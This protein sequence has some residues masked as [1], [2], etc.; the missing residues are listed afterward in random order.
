M[1]GLLSG[2]KAWFGFCTFPYVTNTGSRDVRKDLGRGCNSP[3]LLLG[4]LLHPARFHL[5]K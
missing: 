4:D 2:G 1:E 5:L 3:G